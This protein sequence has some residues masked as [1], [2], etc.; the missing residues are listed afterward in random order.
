MSKVT[1]QRVG[2]SIAVSLVG[3]VVHSTP[4]GLCA[5]RTLPTVP[6]AE[7]TGWALERRGRT[8]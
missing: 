5:G 8:M 4:Q 1:Q 6:L 3:H 2:G 7:A